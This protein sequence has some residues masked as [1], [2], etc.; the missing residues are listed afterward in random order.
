MFLPTSPT[1]ICCNTV[2]YCIYKIYRIKLT[3]KVPHFLTM[4]KMLF[5]SQ[6]INVYRRQKS[7]PK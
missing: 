6:K 5:T 7:G 2:K 3:K 1:S 4:W